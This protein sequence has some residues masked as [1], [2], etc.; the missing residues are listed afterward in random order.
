MY[1]TPNRQYKFRTKLKGHKQAGRRCRP[2]FGFKPI[3]K[4][5]FKLSLFL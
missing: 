3:G 5:V 2:V 1:Y 4:K